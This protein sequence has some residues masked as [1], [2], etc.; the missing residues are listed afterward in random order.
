MQETMSEI[1]TNGPVVGDIQI[2]DDLFGF[3]GD[4]VYRRSQYAKPYNPALYHTFEIIG[5]GTQVCNGYEVL[6]WIIKN[7]WGAEW[8]DNGFFKIRRGWNECE[9]ESKQISF[10]MPDF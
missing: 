1:R 10:G 8:G 9:I 6:Y 7:S 4:G 5:Y 2:Y 3:T